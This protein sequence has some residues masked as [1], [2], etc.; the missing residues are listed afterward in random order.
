MRRG[1]M[2]LTRK[3]GTIVVV[4]AF[5][6]VGV[7][8][9]AI[10]GASEDRQPTATAIDAPPSAPKADAVS[11]TV[12]SKVSVLSRDQTP[13]DVIPDLRTD[14]P[15]G[16]A[17]ENLALARKALSEGDR[18]LYV[19]PAIDGACAVLVDGQAGVRSQACNRGEEIAAG[20]GAPAFVIAQCEIA[21]NSS[22]GSC[23]RV[24]A[25]GVVADGIGRVTIVDA[26]GKAVSSAL[27]RNNAYIVEASN[28]DRP[29]AFTYESPA[30]TVRTKLP[31][32]EIPA[33]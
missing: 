4:A 6:I 2:S 25:Y 16:P 23:Q 32:H 33:Q 10:A 20:T 11:D 22:Q 27:V 31:A 5:A 3:T 9:A 19:A 15:V 29:V 21:S 18:T 17:G 8:V 1:Q 26:G 14:A 28:A 30:G 13:E 24:V 7:F 12:R